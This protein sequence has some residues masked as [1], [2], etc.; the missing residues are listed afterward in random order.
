MEIDPGVE[1][2]GTLLPARDA[3]TTWANCTDTIPLA[4][5]ETPKVRV[6][7]TPFGIIFW[8]VPLNTQVPAL[9]ARVFPA[10]SPAAPTEAATDDIWDGTF[11]VHSKAAGSLPE[12]EETD[13][14][15]VTVP[16]GETDADDSPTDGICARSKQFDKK[17]H[18]DR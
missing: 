17:R 11:K 2:T 15:S 13:R 9:H 7:A 6:A 14:L 4:T 5:G 10:A 1:A 12:G 3:A 18:T 16:P 8:L